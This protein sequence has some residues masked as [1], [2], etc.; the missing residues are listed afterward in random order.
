MNNRFF[1]LYEINVK[2]MW[3]GNYFSLQNN[4]QSKE[5]QVLL[6]YTVLQTK[7]LPILFPLCHLKGTR[8]GITAS[9]P[10]RSRFL[11]LTL[12]ITPLSKRVQC[13]VYSNSATLSLTRVILGCDLSVSLS[14]WSKP[15][16]QSTRKQMQG[17]L[18]GI[19]KYYNKIISMLNNLEAAKAWRKTSHWPWWPCPFLVELKKQTISR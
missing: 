10:A 12:P 3:R 19:F 8:F 6:G 17:E 14:T 11:L 2:T 9:S 1:D 7:P 15:E 16:S 13:L 18:Q 5:I 4:T